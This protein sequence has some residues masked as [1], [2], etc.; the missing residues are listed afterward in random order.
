MYLRLG[1]SLVDSE[2]LARFDAILVTAFRT[3]WGYSTDFRDLWFSSLAS[4]RSAR[5]DNDN[6]EASALLR[7]VSVKDLSS[8]LQRGLT[9]FEREERELSLQ[10]FPEML[11]RVVAL[12]R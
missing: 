7:K 2:A 10:L 1:C 8:A 9:V 3:A 6:G 5:A 11:S 12:D 4:A